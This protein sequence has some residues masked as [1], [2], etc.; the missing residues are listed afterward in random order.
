MSGKYERYLIRCCYTEYHHSCRH[1]ASYSSKLHSKSYFPEGHVG[2]P[3][4]KLWR[5]F[6]SHYPGRVATTLSVEAGWKTQ[7]PTTN[8]SEMDPQLIRETVWGRFFPLR[9]KISWNRFRTLYPSFTLQSVAVPRFRFRG[10][11]SLGPAGEWL[12]TAQKPKWDAAPEHRDAW[13]S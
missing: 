9:W 2:E 10:S 12:Q 6:V 5:T 3:P 8:C 7:K 4:E 1:E 13:E 11:G